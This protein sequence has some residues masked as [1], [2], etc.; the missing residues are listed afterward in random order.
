M[1][2]FVLKLLKEDLTNLLRNELLPSKE[3]ALRYFL[4]KILPGNHIHKKK[5]RPPHAR[6]YSFQAFRRIQRKVR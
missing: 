3:I 2:L 5:Y 1:F 6:F 4:N